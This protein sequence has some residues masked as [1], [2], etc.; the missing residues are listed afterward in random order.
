MGADRDRPAETAA[1]SRPLIGAAIEVPAWV[2]PEDREAY[3]RMSV[4]RDEHY[5]AE[6]ARASKRARQTLPPE[7]GRVRPGRLSP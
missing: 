3:R 4:S 6:F 1:E 2:L 7:R 5:A